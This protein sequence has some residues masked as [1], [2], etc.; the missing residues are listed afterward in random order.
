MHGEAT[1]YGIQQSGGS[2]HVGNQAVGPNAH[3]VSRD[4]TVSSGPDVEALLDQVGTLLARHRAELSETDALAAELA[5]GR[6]REE[7]ARPEP[8]RS[9]L[10]RLLGGLAA[11]VRPVTPLVTAVDALVTAVRDAFG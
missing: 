2:S 4:N 3:A 11:F 8:D 9:R 7:L 6:V 5:H 10:E 1:N